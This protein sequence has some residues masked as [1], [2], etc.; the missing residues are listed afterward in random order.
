[1]LPLHPPH[2][3]IYSPGHKKWL[4]TLTDPPPPTRT[5]RPVT[6]SE[7]VLPPT[8]CLST[9]LSQQNTANQTRRRAWWSRCISIDAPEMGPAVDILGDLLE[10]SQLVS[11]HVELSDTSIGKLLDFGKATDADNKRTRMLDT[12]AF[13]MGGV[14]D[15]LG[16]AG[17]AGKIVDDGDPSTKGKIVVPR[18]LVGPGEAGCIAHKFW[19]P[20]RQV[21]FAGGVDDEVGRPY[22]AVRTLVGTTV[23]KPSRLQTPLPGMTNRFWPR[24]LLTIKN[25]DM[26]GSAHAHVEFNPW[27]ERQF[28]VLDE[29]GGWK[30]WDMEGRQKK[31]GN[32]YT[33]REYANG[34]MPVDDGSEDVVGGWGRFCWGGDFNTVLV[35]GRKRA[36]VFDMRAQPSSISQVGIPLDY[37]VRILDLK[38][39]PSATVGADAFVLTSRS[40]HWLDLR[41]PKIPLMTIPH[42]RHE[43]D[44]LLSLELF[45][46]SDSIINALI[47][48]RLNHLITS[49]TLNPT[50]T[51]IPTQLGPQTHLPPP[52]L[53]KNISTPLTYSIS[54]LPCKPHKTPFLH[55]EKQ[56]FSAFSIG[57]DLAISQRLYSYSPSPANTDDSEAEDEGAQR[58][59]E[60]TLEPRTRERLTG[61]YVKSGMYV[62]EDE[63]T[64]AS[65]ERGEEETN[66]SSERGEEDA[67]AK[68]PKRDK[69]LLRE[70][71][72]AKSSRRRTNLG[73]L[74]EHAYIQG[75][76][77]MQTAES[78]DE[79]ITELKALLL[80]RRERGDLG[81]ISLLNLHPPKTL[82]PDLQATQTAIEAVLCP[83]HFSEF[84][85][86]PLSI[87]TTATSHQPPNVQET[88]DSLKDIYLTP[89]PKVTNPK[90]LLRREKL[91]RALALETYL[92]SI[93]VHLLPQEPPPPPAAAP[94][95][96]QPIPIK[97]SIEKIRTYANVDSPVALAPG[98]K[99]VLDAWTL[100]QDP[101]EPGAGL[102]VAGAGSE[103]SSSR[104]RRRKSFVEAAVKSAAVKVVG[105]GSSQPPAML[106]V[107][108]S[109]SET[110][111]STQPESSAGRKVVRK[112]R[113]TGF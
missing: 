74:Y 50:E 42:Y 30:I 57:K 58:E 110:V 14:G 24:K 103:G 79:Y 64:N 49:I 45:N 95:E 19:S 43:S 8:R 26:Y 99:N 36:G 104:R 17:V 92:A 28:G 84:A 88:Y 86:T 11:S 105:V 7:V 23:F 97:E 89:L 53:H 29:K 25:E 96:G 20:I 101:W 27:F 68:G 62:V 111:A 98:M 54:I 47:Y 44:A 71:L 102:G 38:R 52:Y 12:T 94:G 41:Q 48:S 93:G 72:D 33:V 77:A 91:I 80:K 13:A 87:A 112:K 5:L 21:I 76:E 85:I 1:M 108:S 16:I 22:L 66:A 73:D 82:F 81:V 100:G 70:L 9:S 83:E 6:T 75:E 51:S 56:F 61:I 55:S 31:P 18:V 46:L 3:A 4:Q 10:E 34:R 60:L 106:V 65:S 109:Q 107:G 67:E 69:V 32:D 40:L 113:R 35:A 78:V 90:V 2:S 63:E 39:G 15:E 59:R 37:N